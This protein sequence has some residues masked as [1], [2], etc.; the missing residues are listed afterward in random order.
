MGMIQTTR[1]KE[2]MDFMKSKITM[3]NSQPSYSSVLIDEENIE[4]FDMNDKKEVILLLE[5][6]DLRWRNE[7][8]QIMTRMHYEI[9]LS[10]M[11]C[12]F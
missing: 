7:P 10:S 6:S 3:N 12:E 2:F 9:I 1:Y 5:E 8:W 4:V 11:G